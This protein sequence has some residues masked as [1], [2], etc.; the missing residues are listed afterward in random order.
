MMGLEASSK[1]WDAPK[2]GDTSSV[3]DGHAGEMYFV[4]IIVDEAASTWRQG[5]WDWAFQWKN[6]RKV[7]GTEQHRA[8]HLLWMMLQKFC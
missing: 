4:W 8:V 7:T 6:I 3:M 5:S 1:D 2:A